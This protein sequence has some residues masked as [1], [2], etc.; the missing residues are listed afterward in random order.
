MKMQHGTRVSFRTTAEFVKILE[1]TAKA[2]GIE[3]RGDKYNVSA[4]LHHIL[5]DWKN[6]GLSKIKRA[7]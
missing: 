6:N 2:L 4:A 7:S 5:T 1:Q 3:K